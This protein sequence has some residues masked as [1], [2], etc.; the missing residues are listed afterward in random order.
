MRE[1]NARNAHPTG[2]LRKER[3]MAEG[4]AAATQGNSFVAE[5]EASN[6]HPLWD[7]Y[8]R[9]TPIKPQPRDAPFLWRWRDIEPFLHRAVGEVSI[10]DIER[11]ALI[12]A[13]PAFGAETTTTSTL[14][15]A[16]TVL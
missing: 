3:T 9:I 10:N 15:A 8:Q 7:R 1:P 2:R 11:R 12:M 6:L 4:A 14:L 16:F 5:L 13:H